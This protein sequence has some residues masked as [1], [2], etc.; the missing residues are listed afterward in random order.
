MSLK[1][2]DIIE[3][4]K[5]AQS[6][7]ICEKYL[8]L[9]DNCVS[10]REMFDLA[11]RIEPSYYLVKSISEG[12]GVSPEYIKE[13]FSHFINGRYVAELKNEKGGE[14]TSQLWCCEKQGSAILFNTSLYTILDCNIDIF[15]KDNSV[16]RVIADKDSVIRLHLGNDCAV[17]V[18]TDSDN[19]LV[20][21]KGKNS[22][23][24]I[25]K[26]K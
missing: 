10:K 3:F 25:E 11:C 16:C 14:Y 21:E 24:K 13:H 15:I 9:W 22:R 5:N 1:L 12:W 2:V 18:E 7:G 26:L 19:V 4:R 20:A 17:L 8:S 23:T 6:K